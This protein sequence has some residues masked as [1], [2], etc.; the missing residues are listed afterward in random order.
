MSNSNV[1]TD[2]DL[3]LR[4][5]PNTGWMELSNFEG[6]D[7]RLAATICYT[8]H[9]LQLL[10]HSKITRETPADSQLEPQ[11]LWDNVRGRYNT[12]NIR[13][14]FTSVSPPYTLT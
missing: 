4:M 10:P 13:E 5:L 9:T 6:S 2:I 12:G 14:F 8:K 1:V 3:Q 11:I 7:V